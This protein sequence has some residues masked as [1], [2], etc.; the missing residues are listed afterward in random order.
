M[1]IPKKEVVNYRL[2]NL[3]NVVVTCP[4]QVKF[5]IGIDRS[6]HVIDDVV[7]HFTLAQQKANFLPRFL[8]DVVLCTDGHIN[9]EYLAK[10]QKIN[11]VVLNQSL[12]AHVKEKVFIF[13]TSMD[14]T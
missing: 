11:H 10:Q 9:Y 2:T 1:D 5:L 6:G 7:G 4:P 3:A 8:G 13:K 12:G 14:T